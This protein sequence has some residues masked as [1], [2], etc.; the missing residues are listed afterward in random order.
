M[1]CYVSKCRNSDCVVQSTIY[2]KET[3]K[4]YSTL[5]ESDSG[6]LQLH[7]ALL[8]A[9]LKLLIPQH[10]EKLVDFCLQVDKRN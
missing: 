2:C 9:Y 3:S 8:W 7:L 6:M 5:Q 4:C 1:V 10:F